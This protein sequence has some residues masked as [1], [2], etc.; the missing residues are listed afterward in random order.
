[1]KTMTQMLAKRWYVLILM[2]FFMISVADN[3]GA[4]DAA[5]DSDQE[6]T[7]TAESSQVSSEDAD[8][9]VVQRIINWLKGLPAAIKR[10]PA[11]IKGLPSTLMGL[12]AQIKVWINEN[13]GTVIIILAVIV[14]IAWFRD[15]IG[16][17]IEGTL[18]PLIARIV[19]GIFVR[20]G[21]HGTLLNKYYQALQS[22]LQGVGL[23]QNLLGEAVDLEKNYIA[24]QL[25]KEEYTHPE[26]DSE[27]G[28]QTRPSMEESEMERVD[29]N[30]VLTDEK[31]HG[32]RIAIIGDPGSGKTTLLQYLAYQCTK[33]EGVKPIPALITLTAYV[34]HPALNVRSYLEALFADNDFPSAK[35]Y[36]EGQLKKGSFLILFDGFD[37]VEIDKRADLRRQISGFANNRAYQQNKYVI[38]S[39]P[40][41]DATFDGFRHLEVMPLTPSQR[42]TFLESKV[43]DTPGSDFNSER[44]TELANAIEEHDRV[45]K[46]A[47]NP[48]LLTF[49]YHVYKYNLELPR[50]RV[51][52]YRLSVDLMLDWDIKTNRPTHIQVKDRDAKKD[53][54]KRV[55]HY[56]HTHE[57]RA[58]PEAEM[59]AQ[60][61]TYLPDSLREKFTAETLILEIENSSGIVRHRTAD[62]YQFIHLTF[63]EY[64]T[65]DYINGNR[66]EELPKLMTNLHNPW[67]REVT[68]L[69]ASNMGN[70][71]PLVNRIMDYA[72]QATDESEKFQCLFIAFNCLFEAQVDTDARNKVLDAFVKLPYQQVLEVIQ[73]IVG[74]IE[75]G[76]EELESLFVNILNSPHEGV[77]GWGLSF[78]NG[79]PEVAETSKRLTRR[80]EEVC[81]QALQKLPDE[82][83]A[84]IID[85]LSLKQ[86]MGRT[87]YALT[88]D[89]E[90]VAFDYLY[91]FYT[92]C[93]QTELAV[94]THQKLL[95]SQSAH[96]LRFFIGCMHL[97]S[98]YPMVKLEG[99]QPSF[100]PD[101][102]KT[103]PEPDFTEDFVAVWESTVPQF[104]NIVRSLILAANP[105][106]GGVVDLVGSLARDVATAQALDR[107]RTLARDRAQARGLKQAKALADKLAQ[108][109]DLA[110]TRNLDLPQALEGVLD[111]ALDRALDRAKILSRARDLGRVRTRARSLAMDRGLDR[112]WPLALELTENPNDARARVLAQA[113]E[114]VPE[115]AQA[116]DLA[117]DLNRAR[118]QTMERDAIELINLVQDLT[119][120]YAILQA[121][122]L[123]RNQSQNIQ[124]IQRFLD[125]TASQNQET[126]WYLLMISHQIY[127]TSFLN[128]SSELVGRFQHLW[129][130]RSD[131]PELVPYQSAFFVNLATLLHAFG[132]SPHDTFLGEA[133]GEGANPQA[134]FVLRISY[135]LHQILAN[136]AIAEEQDEFWKLLQTDEMWKLLQTGASATEREWLE[137]SGLTSF[138]KAG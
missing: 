30:R 16:K 138:A 85:A 84:N 106:E 113:Q 9:G 73:Q 18:K 51:E 103:Q 15:K 20:L 19:T 2:L 110:G 121:K 6:Q 130:Q 38:T 39:R 72:L 109:Q 89:Q 97:Q 23:T 63:Q 70:G 79:Y 115:L 80:V 50:R 13:T 64:L 96:F 57:R 48:L 44:C 36:I 136:D 53:V 25:S 60:V 22:K 95:L 75:P 49:L 41:R 32:N 11:A 31:T 99:K 12:P 81:R 135:L 90:V 76:N 114:L 94:E 47:E 101:L 24:I 133:L 82:I 93:A 69:L 58:V 124:F 123:V 127:A 119:L 43:D 10:L 134:G 1:M 4:Q 71:T 92:Q 8:S 100:T 52:L 42:R 122:E 61:K 86:I 3:L 102:K 117:L 59:L 88:I 87:W 37:E 26:G 128:P 125:T 21:A 83:Q 137:E 56:Y 40:I 17:A 108:A 29:V 132:I 34:Q 118:G 98:G 112:V 45:R 91:R 7:Q 120:V 65:A 62:E 27:D 116:L 35:D 66:D 78:L 28:A 104:I 55:A 5:S 14:F 74:P 107:D 129:E 131:V 126:S 68:L 54:L 33:E 105:T 77:Q 111:T 67:W 46:L